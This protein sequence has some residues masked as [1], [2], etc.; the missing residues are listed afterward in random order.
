MSVSI[1]GSPSPSGKGFAGELASRGFEVILHGRNE[2]KLQGVRTELEREFP[3]R[4]FRVLVLDAEED[5]APS[6]KM[7]EKL[8]DIKDLNLRILVNNIAGGGKHEM[9]FFQSL[10]GRTAENINGTIDVT[11]RFPTQLTRLLLPTLISKPSSLILNIGSG[12]SELTPPKL[13]VY[14]ALKGYNTLFSEGLQ[15]ELEADGHSHVEV[16]AILIFS[17]STEKMPRPVT[18]DVPTTRQMA[19]SSLAATGS[20]KTVIAAYWGHAVGLS[21]M[22]ALPRFLVNQMTTKMAN[23]LEAQEK[24]GELYADSG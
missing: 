1:Q 15:L 21:I 8:S 6:G 24:A 22:G 10:A 13:V 2:K 4:K 17:V 5:S 7:A 9:P 23:Q 20:G 19:R 3:K 11:C 16:I 18:W 12:A 14:G